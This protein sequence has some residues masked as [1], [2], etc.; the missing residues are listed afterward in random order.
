ML[1]SLLSQEALAKNLNDSDEEKNYY[2]A[3]KSYGTTPESDPPQYVKQLSKTGIKKFENIDWIDVGLQYRVR[4]ENRDND[5]RRSY[6]TVDRPILSRSRAYFAVKN[7]L[8][9]LRFTLEVQDSRIQNSKFTADGNDVN[10]LD[11]IQAYGELHFKNAFNLER[12]LSVR[13]GRMS[14]EVLDRRLISRNEWRNTSNNFQGVRTI[15][16]TNEND[17]QLDGFALQPINR[18][19]EQADRRNQNQWFYGAILNWR[20]WSDITTLQPF[21]FRLDQSESATLVKQKIHSP[22]I[23]AYGNIA[24]SNFDYD[25][26]A[27]YQFGENG[28]QKHRASG[29]VAEVG[30]SFKYPW[31]PRLSLNYGYGSGDKNPKDGANQRFEKFFGFGRAWSSSDYLQWENIESVKSRVEFTP[32]KKLRIDSSYGLYWLASS[33]DRWNKVG[34]RDKTGTKGDFIGQEFDSRIRYKV[35]TNLDSTF[36]YSHFKPGKFTNNVGR[37]DSSDFIYLELIWNFFK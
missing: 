30:Y 9:P 13:A 2:I 28:T 8:D 31:Q 36:G 10:K 12:P 20:R 24:N 15:F 26:I 6:N 1:I 16:G 35:T 34:L 25:L 32:T 5:F 21:Y 11:F 27:I 22:G 18:L 29:Y 17:W 23:R 3:A 4:F 19:T 37:N 33:S 7:I 14:F